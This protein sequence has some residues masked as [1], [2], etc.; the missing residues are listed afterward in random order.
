MATWTGITENAA[1]W[2]SLDDSSTEPGG[3]PY[4]LLLVLT[5]PLEWQTIVWS[6]ITENTATWTALTEN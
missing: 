5:Q 6:G 3:T 1:T 2:A 4:G